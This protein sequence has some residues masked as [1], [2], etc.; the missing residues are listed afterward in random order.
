MAYLA[1]ITYTANPNFVIGVNDLST[2]GSNVVLLDLS[3]K[4]SLD[5]YHWTIQDDY[6]IALYSA[7]NTLIMD[8]GNFADYSPFGLANYDRNK[9]TKTQQWNIQPPYIQNLNNNYRIDNNE[10]IQQNN[11]QIQAY[12]PTGSEAQMWTVLPLS[13]V[14]LKAR[15]PTNR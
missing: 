15:A 5:L 1:Q 4:P 2:G 8:C 7:G 13:G 11:N 9:V 12:E 3:T 10:R 6:T 14:F